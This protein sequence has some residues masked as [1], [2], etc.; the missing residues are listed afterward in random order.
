MDRRCFVRSIAAL[1]AGTTLLG[2]RNRA[3]PRQKAQP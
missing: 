2:A 3:Q 1:G